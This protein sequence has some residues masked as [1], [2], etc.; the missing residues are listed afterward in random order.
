MNTELTKPAWFALYTNPRVE[1]KL[2][3]YLQKYKIEAYLPLVKLK[4]KWSDRW[5]ITEFP[6]FKSYIFVKIV[7]WEERVKVLGLPGSHHFVFSKG[8][9]AIIPEEDLEVVRLFVENYPDKVKVELEENLK[10]GKKILIT[11]GIFKGHKAE[12]EKVK[13]K[14]TVI[15]KLPMMNQTAKLELDISELG[16]EE[17]PL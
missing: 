15:V 8:E 1:K 14:A 9:P 4:K 3:T 5:R 6:L 17:L 13:S 2:Y 10:P 11:S 12:V 16:I 7:F